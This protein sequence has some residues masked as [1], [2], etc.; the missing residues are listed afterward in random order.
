MNVWC[1]I[2]SFFFVISLDRPTITCHDECL[3]GCE[4]I[5]PNTCKV[6]RNFRMHDGGSCVNKCPPDLFVYNSLCVSANFCIKRRKQ[7]LLGECRQYCDSMTSGNITSPSQCTRSCGPVEVDSLSTSDMVRGCQ[8]IRGDLFIRIQS[9]V[10]NTM[11]YLER[12][13]GDIEEI[14]GV[15]KVYR[16][17]VITSLSFLRNLRVIRGKTFDKVKYTIVMISNENLQELWD[18]NEKKS[19]RLERG[20]LLIHFN[21]KLC[22]S[23]IREL[24]KILKTNTSED[25]VSVDSNGYEQTCS[26]K[27]IATWNKVLDCKTVEISWEKINITD[28][29][30]IMGYIIFYVVAPERNITH[31]GIDTCVQ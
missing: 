16:S 21:S 30:K 8:I 1:V 13:L 6:C 15:L 28:A 11:Q 10:V 3:G 24:Q 23:Q 9:G 20:N 4:D 17:P 5:T 14:E 22:L 26:A 29:E 25:F 31:R 7:P 2:D 27:P 12:N 19:L 18:F